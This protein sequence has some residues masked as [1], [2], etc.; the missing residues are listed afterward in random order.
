MSY[1]IKFYLVD[2]YI[3]FNFVLMKCIGEWWKFDIEVVIN[4][5]LKFGLV[6]NVFDVYIIN[7]YLGFF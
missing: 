6:L 1:L 4:E 2:S 3:S 5:V 7:G